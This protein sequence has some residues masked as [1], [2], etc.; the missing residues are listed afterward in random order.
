MRELTCVMTYFDARR[1]LS[2]FASSLE[3]SV[4]PLLSVLQ[5]VRTQTT[6]E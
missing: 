4:T 5:Q 6:F 3:K 1:D 2:L